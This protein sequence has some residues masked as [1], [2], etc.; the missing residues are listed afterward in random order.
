MKPDTREHFDRLEYIIQGSPSR[1]ASEREVLAEILRS[2]GAL[3]AA[4]PL[5]PDA[6]YRAIA[7]RHTGPL[8]ALIAAHFTVLA[9]PGEAPVVTLQAGDVLVRVGLPGLGHVAVL[10]EATLWPAAQLAH[11]PFSTESQR[12]GFYAL[13]ID[14]GACPHTR[15]DLF[16]RC[17]LDAAG[18]MPSGQLLLRPTL[19]TGVSTLSS[20]LTSESPLLHPSP[21]AF[22][23]EVETAKGLSKT[24]TEPAKTK[25]EEVRD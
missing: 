10:A 1:A 14:P 3:F 13:V 6:L 24:L 11:A 16:A 25:R 22:E 12:R 21:V 7:F 8:A 15:A 9:R 20:S 17:V 19:S 4:Q 18:R 2:H 5:D 23:E